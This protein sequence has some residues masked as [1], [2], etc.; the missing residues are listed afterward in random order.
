MFF[1]VTEPM[2]CAH[3]CVCIYLLYDDLLYIYIYIYLLYI[4]IFVIHTHT[5]I[6]VMK[7]WLI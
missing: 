6:F 4:Y 3:V 7:N 1:R 2:G 5:Y